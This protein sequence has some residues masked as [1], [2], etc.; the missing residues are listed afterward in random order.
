MTTLMTG[1]ARDRQKAERRAALLRSARQLM[2]RQGYLSVRLEDIGRAAGVSGPAVYRH[3]PSKGAVLAELL[4][5][6]SERLLTGGRAAERSCDSADA[7]LRALIDLH[8]D[9]ALT[10]PE[11]ILI[12][13]RDRCHLE[14]A[15]LDRMLRTQRRYVA[16]W[17]KTV[18]EAAPSGDPAVDRIRVHAVLGLINSTPRASRRAPKDV[19]HAVVKDMALQS[20]GLRADSPVRQADSGPTAGYRPTMA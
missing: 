1:N 5:D 7:L 8:V 4:I 12:D 10:E 16:L 14:P 13:D 6:V 3:F 18:G 19:T 17:V 15:A 2:A 20:L 11:L 9:F